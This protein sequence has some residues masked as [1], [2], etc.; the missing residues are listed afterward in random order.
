VNLVLARKFINI[1]RRHEQ[2]IEKTNDLLLFVTFQD[3]FAL[4]EDEN[5]DAEDAEEEY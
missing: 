2:C 5:G 3:G 1:C 4:P